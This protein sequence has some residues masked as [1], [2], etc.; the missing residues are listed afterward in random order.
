DLRE[1]G[2]IAEDA[3]RWGLARA[4]PDLERELPE[5]VRALIERKLGW[6]GDA[7]RR[8]LAAASVQGYEFDSAVV[9]EGLELEPAEAEER[10]QV[11][12]RVHG[13]VRL[14]REEELPDRTLTLRYGFV[15]VLYQNV[16]HHALPPS[17]RA[18]WSAALAEALLRH[19]RDPSPTVAAEL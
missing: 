19:H 5:S 10:L 1:R 3:G 11:L 9:A 14:V 16:L 4:V 6:L 15:H 18:A 2:V 12:D 17:R 7:D 8:L 13:L